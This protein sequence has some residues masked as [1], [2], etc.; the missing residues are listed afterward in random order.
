MF[1]YHIATVKQS[2]SYFTFIRLLVWATVRIR[3][4]MY[5]YKHVVRKYFEAREIQMCIVV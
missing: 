1:I 4:R 5:G 3:P 2:S